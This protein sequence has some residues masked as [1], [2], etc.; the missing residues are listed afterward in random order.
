M[1]SLTRPGYAFQRNVE[2]SERVVTARSKSRDLAGMFSMTNRFT[3]S[4]KG[5]MGVR[6]RPFRHRKGN[7]GL[8]NCPRHGQQKAAE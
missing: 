8:V 7:S 6:W 5:E 1:P 4:G 2:E 3:M